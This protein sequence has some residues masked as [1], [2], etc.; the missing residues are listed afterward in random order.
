MADHWVRTDKQEQAERRERIL[1]L[2]A[3]GFDQEEIA[4]QTGE[5]GCGVGWIVVKARAAGDCRAR[6]HDGFGRGARRSPPWARRAGTRARS[7][8]RVKTGMRFPV[9]VQELSAIA[10]ASDAIV[11][12]CPPG[13]PFGG[14]PRWA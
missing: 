3:A 12:R 8:M 2:W 9:S 6:R 1:E 13:I 14:V 11:D 5:F 10:R 4:E 7:A